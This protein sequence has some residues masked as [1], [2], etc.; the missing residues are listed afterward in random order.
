MLWWPLQ[1]PFARSPLADGPPSWA[2][3]GS[4]AMQGLLAGSPGHLARHLFG[5]PP[6]ARA[7]APP[8]LFSSVPLGNLSAVP[9]LFQS[10]PQAPAGFSPL[11]SAAPTNGAPLGAVTWGDWTHLGSP[12]LLDKAGD[13]ARLPH[14]PHRQS[15]AA[16]EPMCRSAVAAGSPQKQADQDT[17]AR[18]EPC[19][20]SPVLR[21]MAARTMTTAPGSNEAAQSAALQNFRLRHSPT[22]AGNSGDDRGGSDGQQLGLSSLRAREAEAHSSAGSAEGKAEAAAAADAGP[23]CSLKN[24]NRKCQ[25]KRGAPEGADGQSGQRPNKR[26]RKVRLPWRSR[27]AT[28]QTSESNALYASSYV[29]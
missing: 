21:F 29:I 15:A 18:D 7:V 5:T 23:P 6:S 25:K 16:S 19:I 14:E 9:P 2:S 10:P 28:T 11:Q 17:G 27:D 8:P 1:A 24:Q 3:T 4:G 13:P 20:P 22:R 12:L 26:S